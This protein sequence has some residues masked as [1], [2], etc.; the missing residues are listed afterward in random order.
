MS[1]KLRMSPGQVKL[2]CHIGNVGRG[3]RILVESLQEFIA[4]L[5][6]EERTQINQEPGG[7]YDTLIAL[8]LIRQHRIVNG[9]MYSLTAFGA[10]AKILLES[11]N[12]TT[13]G[14]TYIEIPDPKAAHDMGERAAAELFGKTPPGKQPWVILTYT[15]VDFLLGLRTAGNGKGIV[16]QLVAL[17]Y[18]KQWHD[19]TE[20]DGAPYLAINAQ[21]I[22]L[23]LY[24]KV[25]LLQRVHGE[26]HV[27]YCLTDAGLKVVRLM[28]GETLDPDDEQGGYCVTI[29]ET[30]GDWTYQFHLGVNPATLPPE[31]PKVSLTAK[32]VQTLLQALVGPDHH[33]R[34]L[35]AT[36]SLHKLDPV[37]YG[38][39]IDFLLDE[40]NAWIATQK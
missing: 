1:D 18:A 19:C 21:Q 8:D 32:H 36:R 4:A 29:K 13:D 25:Q 31:E 6:L 39:P 27:S 34:E 26:D 23:M 5:P 30:G 7:D 12:A 40:Y 35:Q 33:I 37:K 15:Q 2:L 28:T 14:S 11:D 3:E 22:D 24:D 38:N 16:A 9:V 17:K 20:R 10:V